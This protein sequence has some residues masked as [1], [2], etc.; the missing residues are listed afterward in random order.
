[1]NWKSELLLLQISYLNF[2]SFV[3]TMVKL[4]CPFFGWGKFISNLIA[5]DDNILLTFEIIKFLYQI[6]SMNC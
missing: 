1:M 6:N 4:C 5:N 3:K 2:G